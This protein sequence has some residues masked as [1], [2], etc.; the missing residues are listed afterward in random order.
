MRKGWR[1]EVREGEWKM[2]MRKAEGKRKG[3]E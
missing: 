3:K 2:E 1:K